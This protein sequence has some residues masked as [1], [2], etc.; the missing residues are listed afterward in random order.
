MTG[1]EEGYVRYQVTFD[2]DVWGDR[3]PSEWAWDQIMDDA[4]G[5]HPDKS[6]PGSARIVRIAPIIWHYHVILK[7]DHMVAFD[8]DRN[9]ED[10]ARSVDPEATIQIV[11]PCRECGEERKSK[12]IVATTEASATCP[13]C[14]KGVA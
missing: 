9:L 4:V 5:E 7:C 10:E 14:E 13:A 6:I 3:D 11:L 2:F 8:I 12:Q 1:P